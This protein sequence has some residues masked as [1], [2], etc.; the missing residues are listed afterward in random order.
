MDLRLKRL[1]GNTMIFTAGKF[2][3]KLMVFF[4]MPL[5]TACLSEAQYSTADL[6]TQLANLLIPLACLGIS[7]GIFRNAAAKEGDKEAFFSSGVAIL[8]I[9][10][11]CFLLLSPL[12][13]LFEYFAPYLWLIVLFVLGSNVHSVC[14]Q[15]VCAI[16]KTKTFAAQGILNTALNIAF[17]LL[18]LLGFGMKVEGYVLSV[19][20]ADF[21]TTL[22]LIAYCRLWR[23]FS[24]KKISKPLMWDMLRFSLPLI[25]TTVFWWITG[26][27]DRYLVARMRSDTENG[28]Y[29]AAYK[30]PTLLTYMVS[31]F[32]EAWR[33]SAVRESDNE[34]EC[35]AFF[36]KVFRYYVAI[37]FVGGAFLV[38]FAKVCS[39]I[40]F[41]DSYYEA[42]LYVPILVVATVF[43]SFDSFLATAYFTKKKTMVS[44]Y[45][46]MLGAVLNIVLN[47]IWIPAWGAVGASLA[48]FVSYFAV[49]VLRVATMHYFIRFNLQIPRITLNTVLLGGMVVIMM[50]EP[51]FW[52]LW[53]GICT[54]IVVGVNAPALF[55]MLKMLPE[56]LK[57]RLGR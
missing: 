53:I 55:S 15:Y 30:I 7:E 49:F 46:S 21:V 50:T 29:A 24:I 27:S 16:G 52:M 5:Y 31:V 18:F 13:L 41:A 3:S 42:W 40:L 26:V 8:C 11:L 45:T 9:S 17:N 20:C 6:I 28:L 19:V 39:I 32:N 2:I 44:F 43:T 10:M 47:L 37:V 14:A 4:M 54:A 1:F 35:A 36:S 51:P 56:M 22:V 38:A 57:G 12:I 23:A 25:P 33:L 48:T 34:G